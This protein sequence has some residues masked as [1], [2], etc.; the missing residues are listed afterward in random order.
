M[1][2]EIDI[3]NL[4][5]LKL[6]DERITSFTEGTDRAT[7]CA[8]VYPLIRDAVLRAHPWNFALRRATLAQLAT[9][10]V[11]DYRYAYQLPTDPYCLRV[12]DTDLDQDNDRWKIE[13]RTLVCDASSVSI[14]YI[15]R[16][17]DPMEYD[18]LFVEAL[19]TRLA[20]EIA[21]AITGDV[22]RKQLLMQEYLLKL[23]E[24][25]Q[26]DGHEGSPDPVEVTTLI[27]VRR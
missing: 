13:G 23:Q 21:D 11:Y 1:P 3:C 22:R 26:A 5:L 2:S 18:S 10:P 15:A 24:A 8:L 6:G 4:A 17:T 16:V 20:A 19:A 9:A 7:L 25:R 12:L 27:D 14:R